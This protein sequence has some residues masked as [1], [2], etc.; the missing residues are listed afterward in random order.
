MLN[1][2]RADKLSCIYASCRGWKSGAAEQYHIVMMELRVKRFLVSL[3]S[4]VTRDHA[5]LTKRMF[6]FSESVLTS[7]M[8]SEKQSMAPISPVVW[9]RNLSVSSF[10]TWDTMAAQDMFRCLSCAKNSI[11]SLHSTG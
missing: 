6:Q 7:I 11:S 2:V 3:D 5:S 10:Y 8:P 1:I 9:L 4:P